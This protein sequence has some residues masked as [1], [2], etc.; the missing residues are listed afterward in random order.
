MYQEITLHCS[1]MPLSKYKYT[2]IYIYIYTC[3]EGIVSLQ[4]SCWPKCNN[5]ETCGVADAS[6]LRPP[7]AGTECETNQH[8]HEQ[9]NVNP[10]LINPG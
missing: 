9:T 3:E 6:K 2:Y 4:S 7:S 1:I 8:K 10:G 5:R